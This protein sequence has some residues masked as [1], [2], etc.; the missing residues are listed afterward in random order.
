VARRADGRLG[1]ELQV[2]ARRHPELTCG[3]IMS[4]DVISVGAE[5]D[6]SVARKLLLDSGVRLLPVLDDEGRPLGGIGL[7]ELARR[8][9]TVADLMAASSASS[10]RPTCSPPSPRASSTRPHSSADAV[11]A[12]PAPARDQV[13]GD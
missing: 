3:E 6:P 13:R 12:R 10:P 1:G 5:A 9:G 4:R 2:L 7:R 11:P 8:G